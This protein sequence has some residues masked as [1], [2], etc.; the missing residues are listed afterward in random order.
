MGQLKKWILVV[1]DEDE[2]RD[3]I[4]NYLEMNFNDEI[5]VIT[6]PDGLVA[7]NKLPFQ[8]FDCIITD[9]KMP[10]REGQAF[11]KSIKQSPLNENTPII[12]ITG[13]PDPELTKEHPSIHLIE[14]PMKVQEV[15][16]L[17]RTQI[18][19]GKMD[20]R[21][22]A[23]LLNALIESINK[24]LK[25]TLNVNSKQNKPLAKRP[26]DEPKGEFIRLYNLR[27]EK[28]SKNQYVAIGLPKLILDELKKVAGKDI[29]DYLKLTQAAGS[30][31]FKHAIKLIGPSSLLQLNAESLDG[32]Q[33]SPSLTQLKKSK[34]LIIPVETDLGEV[35][36][37]AF[38]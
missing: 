8:A 24:F 1:D 12:V 23:D 25:E 9:L 30:L 31:I 5:R 33:E 11:I 32:T 26:G 34:G 37:Q 4:A 21:L 6:A 20:Q 38:W 10:K 2:I 35:S 22:G 28:K 7:S 17:V 13:A 19:L 29:Q 14:K 18:K 3:L 16:E 15:A 27:I 36:I